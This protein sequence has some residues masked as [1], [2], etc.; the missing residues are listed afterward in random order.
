METLA[1]GA[2]WQHTL[3]AVSTERP[4]EFIDI[5]NRLEMLVGQAGVRSGILNLQTLH[6][7]T[8]V[9]VNEHEP[10]LFDDFESM[11]ER[12]APFGACY[13]HDDA[14][15]RRVNVTMD[16]RVNGHAHCRALLLSASVCLNIVSSRIQLGA[17]Q[18]VFLVELD[19]PRDRRLSA[20]I[21]GDAGDGSRR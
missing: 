7:T 19:G 2:V 3:I 16:E 9:V 4:T 13:R 20:M 10:L 17:W 8:A 18:R 21:V 15:V 6:T 11:F 5:T 12:T 14:A 1:P